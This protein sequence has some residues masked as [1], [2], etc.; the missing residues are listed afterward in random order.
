MKG[1]IPSFPQSYLQ[2]PSL[3]IIYK[4]FP[5]NERSPWVVICSCSSRHVASFTFRLLQAGENQWQPWLC[6]PLDKT[7]CTWLPLRRPY[8]AGNLKYAG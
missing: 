4:C 6:L 1:V 5:K 8:H 3:V 2:Q 7:A